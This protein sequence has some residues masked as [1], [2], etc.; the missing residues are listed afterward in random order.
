M[1]TD[2]WDPVTD[3]YK[4]KKSS[5]NISDKGEQDEIPESSLDSSLG[6]YWDPAVELCRNKLET[7]KK[8]N[9]WTSLSVP[10]S[11]KGTNNEHKE[12]IPWECQAESAEESDTENM[13]NGSIVKEEMINSLATEDDF[14]QKSNIKTKKSNIKTKKVFGI[15]K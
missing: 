14:S 13:T 2:Y 10:G 1:E 4:S 6:K 3:S 7:S 12:E 9:I 11:S 15:K 5:K 8:A